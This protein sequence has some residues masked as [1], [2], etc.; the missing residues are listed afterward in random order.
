MLEGR[1]CVLGF[2]T[3]AVGLFAVSATAPE[4]LSIA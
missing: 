2:E 1:S 4:V 3:S